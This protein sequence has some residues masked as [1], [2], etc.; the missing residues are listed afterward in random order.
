MSARV[1]VALLLVVV[2]M[3]V[4]QV[5][6]KATA[7]A[8]QSEGALLTSKVL[9]RLLPSLVVYALATLAWIWLL[10][11]VELARAYPF[12]ALAFVLVPILSAYVFGESQDFRY[13]VGVALICAGVFV[14]GSAHGRSGGPPAV[15]AS[16]D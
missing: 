16:S 11:Y 12:M 2:L 14:S 6:F 5:L 7:I 15:A 9:A 3:A 1:V 10:Q 8:W 13:Y 4:G